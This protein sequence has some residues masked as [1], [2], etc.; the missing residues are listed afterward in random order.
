MTQLIEGTRF[1]ILL[2]AELNRLR[3]NL[4]AQQVYDVA[5]ALKIPQSL[6]SAWMA[7]PVW[8]TLVRDAESLRN[9]PRCPN[10]NCGGPVRHAHDCGDA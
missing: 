5:D 7:R 1:T 9:V 2:H 10:P 8:H 6:V 4:P 3:R